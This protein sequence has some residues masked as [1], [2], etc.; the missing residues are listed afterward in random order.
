VGS[1]GRYVPLLKGWLGEIT[2]LPPRE[3]MQR[4]EVDQNPTPHSPVIEALYAVTPI[5]GWKEAYDKDISIIYLLDADLKILRCNLAWDAFAQTNDGAKALSSEVLGI[6][7][8][9]IVPPVLQKFYRAA[10]DNVVR[11]RRDWWHNFECSSPS[12]ARIY[13][14]RILPCGRGNLL[15]IN[16]LISETPLE[17]EPPKHLEDYAGKD[18][19]AIMCSNCR[20]V[21]RLSP[22][23]PWEWI[24]ELLWHGRFSITSDLCEFCMAYH[25]HVR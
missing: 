18:G 14:M 21:K 2:P 11:F 15:T 24:P 20:R 19:R 23:G 9:D 7:I 16:T 6:P 1:G 5:S 8:M 4:F 17:V 12:L 10:Y 25:Y 13:Q 3:R 22:P